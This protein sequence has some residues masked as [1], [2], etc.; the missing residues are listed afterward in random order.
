[1]D[2][3]TSILQNC[4]Y[5]LKQVLIPDSQ[6]YWLY[7]LSS[8]F[9]T[10][11]LYLLHL[12]KTEEKKSL[13]EYCFPKDVY[14]HPSAI[15]DYQN[16]LPMALIKSFLILPITTVISAT[17]IAGAVSSF[18]IYLTGITTLFPVTE[19]QLWHHVAFSIFLIL[20][21]DF[22]YFYNHYLRH[23][24]P[25]L[26]V[27]HKVHHTAEVLTPFT[28]FRHHP[29]DYV[30]QT[31]AVSLCSGIAVGL[32]TYLFGGQMQVL[33]LNGIPFLLFVFYLTGNFRHSHI[34][35]AFPYWISHYFHESGSTLY[36]SCQRVEVL[37]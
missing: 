13:L 26:W 32:W 9:I 11:L 16:Y 29:L 25:L 2:I 30:F 18:L 7:L 15:L 14:L 37:R 8:L 22:G 17:V 20:A 36:S 1:M 35:L 4:L 12:T 5:P 19:P 34:W 31:I 10:L 23:E 27:F 24:I 21:I 28:L 3:I 33:Y 6:V